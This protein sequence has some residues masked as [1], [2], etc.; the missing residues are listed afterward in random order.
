MNKKHK[1]WKF[2]N[3]LILEINEKL[4]KKTVG[5]HKT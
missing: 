3:D 1:S 2:D 5:E 4:K